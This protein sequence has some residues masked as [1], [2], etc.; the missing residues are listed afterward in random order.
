MEI[1]GFVQ[2]GVIILIDG[3]PLPEG[4]PVTVSYNQNGVSLPAVAR[5]RIEF[6]LI[7]TGQ[8]GSWDLTNERIAE[9]LEDDD[10]AMTKGMWNVPS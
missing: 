2:N 4:L 6:P 3:P 8:P 1:S 5:T 10:F 7:R 9:I